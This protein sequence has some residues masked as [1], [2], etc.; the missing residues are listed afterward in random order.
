M[1]LVNGYVGNLSLYRATYL[2]DR[3]KCRLLSNSAC[4]SKENLLKLHDRGS[5][6]EPIVSSF[7]SQ[8]SGGKHDD[9]GW[10]AVILLYV[11]EK[12]SHRPSQV[13]LHDHR[14]LSRQ[15]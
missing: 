4:H 12:I 2:I 11:T 10:M 7:T 13:V 8:S 1:L 15:F 3:R 6:E 14:R 9:W 5:L